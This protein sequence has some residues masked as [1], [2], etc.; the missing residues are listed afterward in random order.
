MMVGGP[1]KIK[2]IKRYLY[3]E[4]HHLADLIPAG[5]KNIFL[6]MRISL[7]PINGIAKGVLNHWKP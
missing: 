2:G 7:N 5:L 6:Y 1:A 4:V 3:K